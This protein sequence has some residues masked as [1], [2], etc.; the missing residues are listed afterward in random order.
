MRRRK[1]VLSQARDARVLARM[2]KARP[3]VQTTALFK[4]K[5]VQIFRLEYAAVLYMLWTEV[6]V[7][8]S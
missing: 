3:W 1:G 5:K 4:K 6:L 7:A 8:G 2:P